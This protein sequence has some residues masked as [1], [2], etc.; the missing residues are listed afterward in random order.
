MA[1]R[2]ANGVLDDPSDDGAR[3]SLEGVAAMLRDIAD[4]RD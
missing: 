2:D 3:R 4:R 1:A